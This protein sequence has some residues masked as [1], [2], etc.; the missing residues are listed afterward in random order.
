MHAVGEGEA[1]G[2]RVVL[3]LGVEERLGENEPQAEALGVPVG[4]A[5]AQRD[6]E[7]EGEELRLGEGVP[8][9]EGEG[10]GEELCVAR[11]A[12]GVSEVVGQ[13]VPLGLGVAVGEES[14]VRERLGLEVEEREAELQRDNV[15]SGVAE[16]DLSA[17]GEVEGVGLSVA[18][19]TPDAVGGAPVTVAAADVAWGEREEQG[20]GDG[21]RDGE[22]VEEVVGEGGGLFKGEEEREGALGEAV[23]SVERVREEQV[24]GEVVGEALRVAA[25]EEGKEGKGEGE[26]EREEEAQ[27]V[28]DGEVVAVRTPDVG[29]GEREGEREEEAQYVAVGEVVAEAAAEVGTGERE[30]DLESDCV[31]VALVVS[32]GVR[33][34][35][36]VR[37]VE[38]EPKEDTL[39]EGSTVVERESVAERVRE[40]VTETEG[41][42]AADLLGVGE[43]ASTHS[44][45]TRPSLPEFQDG[46]PP[47]VPPLPSRAL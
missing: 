27:Y 14:T 22:R 37:A 25:A 28:A 38:G 16:G 21:V 4:E 12:E 9:A 47:P 6:M 11:G 39:R 2:E 24:V 18:S 43:D 45:V 26:G 19:S 35:E 5:E 40:S 30:G 34:E 32:V 7:G 44:T 20:V 17:E 31:I 13:R 36:A 10:G 15:S 23:G 42:G 3:G 41:V 29:P 1:V 46:L 33:G 8:E